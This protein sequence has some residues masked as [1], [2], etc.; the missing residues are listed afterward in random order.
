MENKKYLVIDIE[1]TGLRSAESKITCIC[2]KDNEDN[3][4][5]EAGS[6]EEEILKKFFLFTDNYENIVSANGKDFDIPF[7]LIRAYINN[8]PHH[9]GINLIWKKHFDIIN[10]VTSSRISLDNLARLFGFDT[11][12]GN[13]LK[14]IQLYNEAKYT[15]LVSYCVNDVVLTEKIYLKLKEIKELKGGVK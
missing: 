7:I 3:W 10:D 2:A 8:I 9:F 1:T 5:M 12:T 13:G 15:E 4:F 11:K 14:A 6:D